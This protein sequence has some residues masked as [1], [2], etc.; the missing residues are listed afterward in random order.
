MGASGRH[1]LHSAE[2]GV[3][4]RRGERDLEDR[5]AT[6]GGNGVPDSTVDRPQRKSDCG[7]EPHHGICW[8]AESAGAQRG[9][10]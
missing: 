6:R 8:V 10:V 5:R 2:A 9:R 3:P 4:E 1:R 7:M